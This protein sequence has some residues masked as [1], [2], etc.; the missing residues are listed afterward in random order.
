MWAHP[1]S[2]LPRTNPLCVCPGPFR[3][4]LGG[5]RCSQRCAPLSGIT[6]DFEMRDDLVRQVTSKKRWPRCHSQHSRHHQSQ[7]HGSWLADFLSLLHPRF[8]H[9]EVDLKAK[10]RARGRKQIVD[11]L[12]IHKGSF[13]FRVVV[14]PELRP[15]LGRLLLL[16]LPFGLTNR[17]LVAMKISQ[18]HVSPLVTGVIVLRI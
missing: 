12:C 15:S 6:L 18:F 8:H 14:R 13:G 11:S 16:K 5:L 2:K 9:G 17:F 3:K 10:P 1:Q 7:N 4:G